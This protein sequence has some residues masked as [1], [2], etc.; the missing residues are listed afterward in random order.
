M[1]THE[2]TPN[3]LAR[4]VWELQSPDDQPY[5]WAKGYKIQSGPHDTWTYQGQVSL[6]VLIWQKKKPKKI[7]SHI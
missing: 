4:L 7:T 6:L 1:T 5:W 3:M 2:V